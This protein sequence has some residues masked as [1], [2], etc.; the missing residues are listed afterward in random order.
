G[1]VFALALIAGFATAAGTANAQF[2][3]AAKGELFTRIDGDTVRAAIQIKIEEGW[4][5]Y[6]EDLGP[7]V[8]KPTTV[9]MGGSGVSWSKVRFPKA[10]RYEQ[11]GLGDGGADTWVNGHHGTIVLYASGKLAG[12]GSAGA[13]QAEIDGLT[14]KES[15]IPYNETVESSG[16]GPDALFAAFPKNLVPPAGTEQGSTGTTPSGST[17]SAGTTG[18]TGATAATI[19]F[20]DYQ[21]RESVD[22]AASPTEQRGLAVWL[23]FAFIAG[24]IL[25][26]MPCVLPVI[27]IKVLS[28]VQQAGESRGRV[29][30]L[31][32]S[33]A[34]G[35][36]VVFMILAG[37]VIALNYNWGEQFQ[38]PW[39]MIG[40]IGLIFAMALWLFGVFEMGAPMVSGGTHREGLVGAFFKGVLATLLATPCSGPFLGSTMAWAL[41][42]PSM[43]I[44]LVFL[45]LGLGMA[46]PYVIL[47]ANPKFL[48]LLPRPGIWMD[49]FKQ[50]MAF[51][52]LIT[53]VYLMVSLKSTDLLFANAFLVFVAFGCWL[54]GRYG[55]FSNPRFKRAMAFVVAASVIGGGAW[56]SFGPLKAAFAETHD[57]WEPFDAERF[58]QLQSEGEHVFIDF[59][60]KWCPNCQ[61]NKRTVYLTEEIEAL[62]RQKNVKVF[63]ADITNEG[64]KT[65][66]IKR[67]MKKLGAHS[68][69]F[70]AV[71][72]KGDPLRP[73]VRYDIVGQ[74]DFKT[75]LQSLPD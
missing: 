34:A 66:E 40:M 22:G 51:V 57:L 60:A 1:I 14:C 18:T 44:F 17:G 62:F 11:P 65:A 36:L 13:F 45:F 67:L 71:F 70:M 72:P 30:A 4:H 9:T 49:T 23:V 29:F 21:P 27:S 8:G 16:E 73:I 3:D 43:T 2:E 24:M 15:C 52:L 39:F 41:R 26:V 55:D 19:E 74:D 33:F 20:P 7:G 56:V 54:W 35:I 25:N 48:R 68:I 53:V 64:P 63:K 69:P 46:I 59:T 58:N 28:F 32:L 6:D 75:I 38:K 61:Y 47:T 12:A 5:L 42:Q 50:A 37:L 10:E 31:G